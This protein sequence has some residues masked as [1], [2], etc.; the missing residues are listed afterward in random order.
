MI[1][2]YDAFY[3]E[4]QFWID[5]GLPANTTQLYGSDSET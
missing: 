2:Q 4:P 5:E 1:H 3:A